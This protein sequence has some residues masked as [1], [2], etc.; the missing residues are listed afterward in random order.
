M[1]V[2][3]LA[4]TVGI[5]LWTAEEMH[6]RLDRAR[7]VVAGHGWTALLVTPGSDLRYFTGYEAMP[8]ERLTCLVLPV[9]GEPGDGV[10]A[11]GEVSGGDR[12]LG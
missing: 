9:S 2:K 3:P 6:Q 11:G 8:L 5:V 4:A 1:Y 12:R 7:R 10:A